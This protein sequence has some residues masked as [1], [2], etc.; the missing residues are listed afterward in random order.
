MERLL[1]HKQIILSSLQYVSAHR[2]HYNALLGIY[3]NG[4]TKRIDHTDSVYIYIFIAKFYMYI[5]QHNLC[6][7]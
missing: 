3:T 4:D 7:S 6:I 2:R 5:L 1:A